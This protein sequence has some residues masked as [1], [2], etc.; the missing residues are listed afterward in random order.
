M[1]EYVTDIVPNSA[2]GLAPL[3]HSLPLEVRAWVSELRTIWAA[4][5]TSIIRFANYG[6]IDSVTLA[7]C[8]NGER[9]PRDR[10]LLNTLLAMQAEREGKEVSWKARR[11][12]F[13]L[14]LKALEVAHPQDY[15]RR[16]ISD[17][18]EVAVMD[19][20]EANRHVCDLEQQL[21]HRINQRKALTGQHDRLETAW[22]AD[23]SAMRA[24]K[25]RLDAE[26]ADLIR[27][28]DPVRR[29]AAEVER[30][31]LALDRLLD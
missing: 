2:G 20:D 17:E 18:L 28:L 16:V 15:R 1:M 11:H 3:D 29:H 25:D 12:L 26:I 30:R 7:M 21:A 31:C 13:G 10:W 14:H 27:C 23:Q 19:R 6:P 9:V 4:A 24:E 8:L 5:G 22:P